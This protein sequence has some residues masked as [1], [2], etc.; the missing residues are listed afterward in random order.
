MQN[1]GELLHSQMLH[2]N[3][4]PTCDKLLVISMKAMRKIHKVKKQKRRFLKQ[5]FCFFSKGMQ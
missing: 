4:N 2:R 3:D 1:I 5:R